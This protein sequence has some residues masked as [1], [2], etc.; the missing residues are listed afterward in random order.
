MQPPPKKG[1]GGL[2][3]II[4][5]IV[6][7]VIIGGIV[8]VVALGGKKGNTTNGNN[9]SSTPTA[10]PTPSVPAGFTKFTGTAFSVVYPSDWMKEVDSQG[11]GGEDFTGTTGQTFQISIDSSGTADEIP[12]LLA[13][14]CSLLGNSTATPTTATVGG[15]QWQQID[16]GNTSTLHVVTEAIFYQNQVYQI[17]YGSLSATYDN[18]KTQFFSVMESSYTFLT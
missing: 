2:I 7:V 15:Q 9:T 3:A 8:A 16:C 1:R 14:F 18:D 13:T 10:T 12:T 6:V 5:I 17:T 4:S 11:G